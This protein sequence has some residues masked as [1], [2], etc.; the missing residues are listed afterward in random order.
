[1]TINNFQKGERSEYRKELDDWVA[2]QKGIQVGLTNRQVASLENIVARTISQVA[3]ERL[4]RITND[5]EY[6]SRKLAQ[7][8]LS[9]S[10]DTLNRWMTMGL[11]YFEVEGVVR[12]SKMDMDAWLANF[13][14]IPS[15][16]KL[17]LPYDEFGFDS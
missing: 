15:I 3:T 16:D 7:E 5:K 1:M 10:E 2:L 11:P 14:V 13:Q 9:V 6:F 4:R 12:F 17:Q 8:Y